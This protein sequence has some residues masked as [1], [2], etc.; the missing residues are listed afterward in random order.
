VANAKQDRARARDKAARREEFLANSRKRRQKHMA[1]LLAALLGLSGLGTITVLLMNPGTSTNAT[2]TPPPV[3]D[4]AQGDGDT[5]SDGNA[6]SE[7][8]PQA[9]TSADS[10]C[11]M[12]EDLVTEPVFQTDEVPDPALA[13]DRDWTGTIATNCGEIEITLDGGAAPQA[14]ASFIEL[15]NEGFY[16]NTAC[17]RLTTAGIFVL[18][19]GDPTG[20]G[21][22][23]PG[24][25]YGP[26]ENAPEDDMYPA[27]TLAMARLG[28]D[29][30]SMGSQFFITYEDS[31][32]PSDAAGGYT[33]LG[34][35]TAG[36]ETVVKIAEGGLAANGVAPQWPI[37]IEKVALQ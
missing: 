20:L 12:P 24:Y 27:G 26:I 16:D 31:Q 23:G 1:L 25:S 32:I 19:C 22:G 9:Q 33:V 21:N 11:P 29:G 14:V 7:G 6:Q 28:G 5:Q 10:P 35:V 36:L 15:S 30:D 18:Q 34:Q 37:A 4:D 17:H 8:D 13:E 2:P 3:D